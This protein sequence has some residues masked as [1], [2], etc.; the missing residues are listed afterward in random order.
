MKESEKTCMYL[1]DMEH[2]ACGIGFI[3]HLKAQASHQIISNALTMLENMEHRGGQSVDENSG[4]GA[5]LMMQLPHSFFMRKLIPLGIELP[6]KGKYGVGM[7]F[8]PSDRYSRQICRNILNEYINKVGLVLLGYRD[9]EVDNSTLG[10]T[11]K[12]TEPKIVQV[13]VEAKQDMDQDSLERKLFVLRKSATHAIDKAIDNSK[14]EFYI[15]TF[16][17]KVIAYKGQFTTPQLRAYY[18]DLSSEYMTAGFAMVHSRFSTNTF[19]KWKLA[20]P[21]RYI[22]HN[23][24]INTIKGNVNWMKS[25]ENLLESSL[26]TR[27]EIEMIKPIVNPSNS[28]SANLDNIIELLLLGGR[29]LAHVMMMLIPEAWQ[30]DT[31]MSELKKSFYRYHASI[32]EPWDGPAS[33][34]FTDGNSIGATLDRNGLRPSRYMLTKDDHIIMASEAG[35]LKIDDKLVKKRGRIQ[36]GKLFMVDFNKGRIIE[37]EEI[38]TMV[39]SKSDYKKWLESNEL[40]ID[41]IDDSDVEISELSDEELRLK[42]LSNSYTREVL[43]KIIKPMATTSKEAIGSMGSDIPL[44]ILSEK[45]PHLS[46]YFKQLFAQVSNPPIDP[47]RERSVMALNTSIGT[48]YNILAETPN[49]ASQISLDQPIL[50]DEQIYK[51]KEL[52]PNTF[53]SKVIDIVFAVNNKNNSLEKA[54]EDICKQCD[55]AI[56]DE[57]ANVLILSDKKSSKEYASI[58]SLL[59]LGSIHHHLVRNRNRVRVGIIV[60][61]ADIFETHHFATLIGYGATAVNPYL[62]FATLRKIKS[63]ESLSKLRQNYIDAVNKGLLKIFAKM[64]ISTLQSYHGSQ[65]FEI[66]GLSNQIVNKSFSGTVSRIGGLNYEDLGREILE[67]HNLAYGGD[68]K[69]LEIGGVYAWRKEGERHIFT[70]DVIANLQKSSKLND[71]SIYKEYAKAVNR[72]T[73]QGSITLRGLLEFKQAKSINL[74]EVEPVE[75]ILKRFV[76]GAMSFGSISWEAHTT[77]AKAM[78]IIGGKSNSGEGGEDPIRYK[79][80]SGE[81]SSKSA[82]KQVASGRFGVTIE[83]LNQAQEIQIKIAQ[84]AKPG[85]GGHLPGHKVDDWI[86]KTRH[87]TPGVGLI[88]PPPH[89]DIYSIEDLAQL[90]YDL[91]NSNPKA[92]INVKL[93]SET[94]VGTIA[95]GVAKAHASAILVSG[96]DGGTGAAPLS[97]IYHAGLPWEM[98]LAEAHQTLVLNGLRNRVV[99]QTDGQLRTGRDL[100]IAALLGAQE[101]GVATA[102]LVVEGCVMQRKCHQ[103][104][105]SVGIATQNPELRKMFTGKVEHLVNF[106]RFLAQDLREIMAQL[107]FK[108]MDEMIGKAQMLKQRENSVHWKHSKIDLSLLLEDF[109]QFKDQTRIIKSAIDGTLDFRMWKEIK[110]KLDAKEK[111]NLHAEVI[112]TDRAVATYISHKLYEKFGK[113]GPSEQIKLNYKGSI[114]QSFGAFAI[115]GLNLSLKGEANDF[116]GKGLSGA[117]MVISPYSFDRDDS[118]ITIGNVAFYGATSGEAFIAGNA[119]ERFAVRNSGVDIV[120]EGVGAHGCEYMTG[121]RVVILGRTGRNFAAGMTGGIA[122]VYDKYDKFSRRVNIGDI[123]LEQLNS[124]DKEFVISKLQEHFKLTKSPK[125]KEFL[126]NSEQQ[127]KYFVKVMP[128]EYKKS[129]ENKEVKTTLI[130]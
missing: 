118:E 93:V 86:A 129:L 68:Q 97:S 58:P 57:G 24:E 124:Q 33:I 38:K 61:A 47:I 71:Y 36:A 94:G 10:E 9:V 122:Y 28:D 13:F 103:N 116:V 104:T 46:H 4:D 113:D 37:D 39:S 127:F 98:G 49:H 88:S 8:F 50:T 100:A 42:H 6:N 44:A 32:M 67:K 101:W 121:G 17:S 30:N 84:G 79:N 5:G 35:T 78:N 40:H 72:N 117:K 3:S 112:N 11:A 48:T 55:R 52:A 7:I 92:R 15:N 60:E 45:R 130:D 85:E 74:D 12:S 119:G 81:V 22:A 62:A 19:P 14:G 90:I 20:Q 108:T 95:A 99:L 34:C 102:A 27:D 43:E 69:Q 125:T 109:S 106:F 70:P 21:F 105:C 77:L 59:A 120:V 123:E 29:S 126:D 107:G 41:Q 80:V 54:L 115:K 56:L 51:I 87:S 91:R 1:P 26:F 75:N 31:K 64:G 66:I 25:Y 23:G 114:G 82:T 16:S 18:K 76:T 63:E 2:D 73:I 83:Y 96:F 110:E 65:I 128:V 53:K 111:V 89:H